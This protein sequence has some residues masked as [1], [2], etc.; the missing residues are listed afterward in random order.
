VAGLLIPSSAGIAKFVTLMFANL[1]VFA[2]QSIFYLIIMICIAN[3]VEYNE[4][5]TGT[6][7][8]GI[9]FSVRPFITKVGWACINLITL[10]IYLATGVRNYTNQI[11]DIENEAA[12]GVMDAA[13][14]SNAIESVLNQIPAGKNAALLACMTIIPAAMCLIAYT[15]YKTKYTIT[16]ERYEQLLSELKQREAIK[17]ELKEEISQCS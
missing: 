5:K 11:A 14:K 2:G 3:T 1:F 7:A 6:R 16:E 17:E 4:W 10:V 9:I 8:E 13:M 15:L 12:K